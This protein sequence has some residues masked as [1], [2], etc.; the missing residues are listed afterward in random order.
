MGLHTGE[1]ARG[2]ERYVGLS[3]HRAARVCA[4]ATGGQILVSSITR[5]LVEEDL[6]PISSFM[7]WASTASRDFDAPQHLF[8]VKAQSVQRD[9]EQ[10]SDDRAVATVAVS[11]LGPVEATQDGRGVDLGTPQQRAF[12]ALLAVRAGEVLPVDAIVDTLWPREPPPTAEKTVQTYV[13]RL[14]KA[15][16][17][18]RSSG[19]APATRAAPPSRGHDVARFEEL[20]A[21]GRLAEALGLWRGPGACGRARR[22]GAAHGERLDGL[23]RPRARGAD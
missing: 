11:V 18:R 7:T 13:S 6:G 19:A 15:L 20:V 14:R 10:P 16:A 8:E 3:V 12:F 1:P 4:A 23:P 9:S 2:G 5:G 17:T 22:G 21:A